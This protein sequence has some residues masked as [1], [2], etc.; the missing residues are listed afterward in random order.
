[1]HNSDLV[2]LYEFDQ[3]SNISQILQSHI[4][5]FDQLIFLDMILAQIVAHKIT[6]VCGGVSIKCCRVPHPRVPSSTQHIHYQSN[7]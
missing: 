6:R 1:M 3:K 2:F 5:I 4:P 7:Q